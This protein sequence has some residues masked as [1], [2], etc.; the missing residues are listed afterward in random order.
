M[1]RLNGHLGLDRRH[2]A[3]PPKAESCLN[4]L[5]VHDGVGEF[6]RRNLSTSQIL[7]ASALGPATSDDSPRRVAAAF[8][9]R[10][11]VAAFLVS[12][13]LTGRCASDVLVVNV[14]QKRRQVAALHNSELDGPAAPTGPKH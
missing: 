13:R 9:V 4:S 1:K 12:I 2:M 6:N 3:F 8:G 14:R 5:C 7:R 11:L 10:Q